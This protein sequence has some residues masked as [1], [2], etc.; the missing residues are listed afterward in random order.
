MRCVLHS[1]IPKIP[2]GFR[3]G[4]RARGPGLWA[5]HE[6]GELRAEPREV[7]L[8]AQV[9][10]R[11][12]VH[13][14]EGGLPDLCFQD[15]GLGRARSAYARAARAHCLGETTRQVIANTAY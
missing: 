8:D 3:K 9:T 11:G 12:A 1:G 10:G 4:A 15:D 14:P 2:K 13:R 5:A 7:N 6:D